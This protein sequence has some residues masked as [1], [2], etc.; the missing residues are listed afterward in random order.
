MGLPALAVA[1][2]PGRIPWL[3]CSK[4]TEELIAV[5]V[6]AVVGAGLAPIAFNRII[7]PT[8]CSPTP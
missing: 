4:V 2:G 5:T 6:L 8:P 1:A 7:K 3:R